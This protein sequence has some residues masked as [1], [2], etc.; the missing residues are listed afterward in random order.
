LAGCGADRGDR[1]GDEGGGEE[2]K[3]VG[4]CIREVVGFAIGGVEG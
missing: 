4:G 2:E 1:G 3:R